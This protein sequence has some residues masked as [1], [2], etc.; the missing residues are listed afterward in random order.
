MSYSSLAFLVQKS[1]AIV[2]PMGY[3]SNQPRERGVE[4]YPELPWISSEESSK[5]LV[6]NTNLYNQALEKIILKR[7]AQWNWLYKRW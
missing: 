1:Q 7:P 5:E 3:Y 6:D 2:I 4:F